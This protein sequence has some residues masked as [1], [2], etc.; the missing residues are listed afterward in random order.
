MCI[1]VGFLIFDI[2]KSQGSTKSFQEAPRKLQKIQGRIPEI[3]SLVFWMKLIFH[4]DILKLTDLYLQFIP[5][6]NLWNKCIDSRLF[7]KYKEGPVLR[8]LRSKDNQC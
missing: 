8:P 7:L 2:T 3:F 5:P 6:I 4:K 1:S